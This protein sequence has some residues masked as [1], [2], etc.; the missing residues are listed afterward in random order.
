MHLIRV[1]V[2]LG[3]LTCSVLP[4]PAFSQGPTQ[5]E[6]LLASAQQAQARGDFE[7]A[8]EFYRKAVAAHPEIPE[9][10][11]NL[12]LMYYQTGK[13]QKA[14]EAFNQ[15][16]RLKPSYAE[17][18]YNLGL[19]LRQ[20][21]R[22]VESAAEF[23]KAYKISPD[24]FGV[25]MDLLKQTPGGVLWL[26]QDSLRARQNLEAAAHAHGVDSARLYFAPRLP[27]FLGAANLG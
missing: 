23:E 26:A 20:D 27:E 16:V 9:L 12:G 5:F 24:I 21:G 17:A 1:T 10:K 3:C 13:N 19:A 25:W 14:I 15:A 18:H 7:S 4:G 8:A 2:V 6:S 11:A 22:L